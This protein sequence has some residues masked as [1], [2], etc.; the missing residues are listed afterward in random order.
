MII[1]VI[2]RRTLARWL[3]GLDH[4]GIVRYGAHGVTEAGV[5]LASA[6]SSLVGGFVVVVGD[7]IDGDIVALDESAQVHAM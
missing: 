5:P 2:G 6:E 1:S 7:C 3:S 4:P